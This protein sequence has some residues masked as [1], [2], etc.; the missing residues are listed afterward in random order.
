M[1]EALDNNC[2]RNLRDLS[3]IFEMVGTYCILDAAVL[4][5]VE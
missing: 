5:K 4:C 2:K 1:F 3:G